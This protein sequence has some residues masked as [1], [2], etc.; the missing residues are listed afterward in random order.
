MDEIRGIL[1]RGARSLGVTLDDTALERFDLYAK[2]LI[3]WNNFMNLTAITK[4]EEIALKHFIDSIALLKY[5]DIK[6]GA[7]TVDVGCG[8]GFPGIPVKIARDDISLCCIDSTAKKVNFLSELVKS[9]ELKNCECIHARAEK[10]AAEKPLRESFDFAFARAV[11][12]L[13]ILAEYCLPL[14]KTGG[15]FAAMKGGEAED[16]INAAKHA[17]ELCGGK[18]ENVFEYVLPQSDINRTIIII[19]KIKSTDKKYPRLNAKITKNPL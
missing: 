11:A 7:K 18:I 10:A 6:S 15:A 19:R 5:A 3:E 9:M 16:E 4:P 13:R 12:Q 17:V 8:A 2:K 1:S 14:V